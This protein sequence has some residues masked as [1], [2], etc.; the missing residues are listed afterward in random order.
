M[1]AIHVSFA[2]LFTGTACTTLDQCVTTPARTFEDRV[3]S[4]GQF[5]MN[6]VD[7][8]IRT[9]LCGFRLERTAKLV[10]G[11][12][13]KVAITGDKT[14]G[15]G[16]V[17]VKVTGEGAI[18]GLTCAGTLTFAYRYHPAGKYPAY[19]E[20]SN[21]E[22]KGDLPSISATIRQKAVATDIGVAVPAFRGDFELP[23]KRL[24]TVLQVE[25][26]EAGSF[27]VHFGKT[28]P[29]FEGPVVTVYQGDRIVKE[30]SPSGALGFWTVEKGTAYFLVTSGSADATDASVVRYESR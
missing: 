4:A 28:Y 18:G 25:I 15:S 6:P 2:L 3:K 29:V 7:S 20:I 8:D 12:P 9:G 17:P 24:A 19:Y 21:V 1:R 22:R 26:A 13:F 10:P 16:E 11:G 14:A 5:E 27:T 30:G 23:D